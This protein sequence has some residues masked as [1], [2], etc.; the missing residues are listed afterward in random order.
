MK[1]DVKALQQALRQREVELQQLI[2]QM[3][4]DQLNGSKVYKNLEQELNAVK[5]RLQG[6]LKG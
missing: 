1:S 2:R 4:S 5:D 6:E 3:K